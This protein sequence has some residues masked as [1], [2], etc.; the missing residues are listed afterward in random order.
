M[1]DW[2]KSMQQTFEYY[3]VN[4]S[5]WGDAEAVRTVR[6]CSITRDLSVDTLGSAT[7]DCDEDLNDKYVRCYLIAIQNGETTKVPLG[8]FLCQT[9]STAFDGKRH[10]ISHDGYTPL[11]ELKEKPMA[12]GFS[13][14]KE[15]NALTIVQNILESDSLRA[16]VVEGTDSTTLTGDFLADVSDTRLSYVSDLLKT[17]K[18]S[19]GLDELGK[20]IFMPDKELSAMAPVWEFTDDNSSILYPDFTTSNDIFGIPNKLEVIYSPSNG[21]PLTSI[22]TNEDPSSIVSH[23]S[24]GRWIIHRETDPDVVD[25]IS[26]DQLNEYAKHRLVELSSV[27]YKITYKHGYCPVRLGDCVRFNY[28]RANFNNQN[29]KVIRQVIRCEEGCP[30]EETAVLTTR[31]W[32]VE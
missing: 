5:T 11:I 26:Q 22:V 31:L 16:P 17:I 27:D 14:R 18:Y 32:E 25:G 29:A 9:P 20:V 21:T 30:V 28:R 10:S 13:A 12:I 7:I 15:L 1:I 23:Q 2:T 8:T 19:L 6:N 3:I 24:R 4:P